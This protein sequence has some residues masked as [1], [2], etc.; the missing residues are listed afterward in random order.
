MSRWGAH[1]GHPPS[2]PIEAP[3]KGTAASR[4]RRRSVHELSPAYRAP[5]RSPAQGLRGMGTTRSGGSLRLQSPHIPLGPRPCRGPRVP[6]SFLGRAGLKGTLEALS[7][8]HMRA[9]KGPPLPAPG[10]G[11]PGLVPK[12]PPCLS[13]SPTACLLCPPLPRAPATGLGP[14]PHQTIQH[15]DTLFPNKVSLTG[16]G[17][18][19]LDTQPTA[20]PKPERAELARTPEPGPAPD[21]SFF[22]QRPRPA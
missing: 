21:L 8:A 4:G 1:A 19:D 15:A 16:A 6:C 13:W 9:P 12:S 11:A 18:W 17:V 7:P 2:F 5:G 22:L 14:G 10:S 20:G 3:V